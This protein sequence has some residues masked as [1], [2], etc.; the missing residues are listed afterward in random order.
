MTVLGAQYASLSGRSSGCASAL[1]AVLHFS[2]LLREEVEGSSRPCLL[3]AGEV[4]FP[5]AEECPGLSDDLER[6][7]PAYIWWPAPGCAY[8]SGTAKARRIHPPPPQESY[9]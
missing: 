5:A 2:E 8:R 1:A 3:L 7:P 4:H 6:P 9:R